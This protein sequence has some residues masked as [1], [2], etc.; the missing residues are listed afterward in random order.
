MKIVWSQIL[1]E[2]A[3]PSID[4]MVLHPFLD[5]EAEQVITQELERTAFQRTMPDLHLALSN[6]TGTFNTRLAG[7][8]AGDLYEVCVYDDLLRCRFWGYIDNESIRLKR[9]S[10]W[11]E[12]DAY[13]AL[14]RFWDKAKNSR[15]PTAHGWPETVTITYLVGI[16]DFICN[17]SDSGRNFRGL[18]FGTFAAESVRGG[19]TSTT[20]GNL[21]R[22]EDLAAETTVEDV[23]RA[24]AMWYNAEFYIDP[25][26]R[27]LKMV[28]RSTILNDRKV[29]L[30]ERLLEDEEITVAALDSETIDYVYAYAYA[31][32]PPAIDS[33]YR[34]TGVV[35]G[36]K[37]LFNGL[38]SWIVTYV[39]DG[40]EMFRSRQFDYTLTDAMGG[41]PYG[42]RL[43]IAPGPS[44]TASRYLYRRDA[45]DKTG[46]YRLCFGVAGNA[47]VTVSDEAGIGLIFYNAALPNLDMTVYGW[48]R[49]DEETDS[50]AA[51][52]IDMPVGQY[53]PRG[54]ILDINPQLRFF[55]YGTKD[56]LRD[57]SPREVF[58][59]F[60]SNFDIN[61]DE[62]RDRWR[63]VFRTRRLVTCNV[64]GIDWEVGDSVICSKWDIIP[65]DL[66]I[67]KRLVVRRSAINLNSETSV[68]DL[69]TV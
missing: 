69:R 4:D 31:G 66:T 52:I 15:F 58:A 7:I 50:W 41:P 45:N 20:Y 9:V 11:M 65:Q 18:N 57:Y 59:F 25:D 16:L 48:Y 62:T 38:H 17:L 49:Y 36:V 23:L 35:G 21:G 60:L 53:P 13:S 67:D 64:S 14:S 54:K 5:D 43:R 55:E 61:A 26:S 34:T 19:Y 27:Q 63:D 24:I 47:L 56:Q 6:L 3:Y 68:L 44:V 28:A 10:E 22:A 32:T 30:A 40:K 29:D 42:V 2:P 46:T 39:I 33:T 51:P 12:F 1:P 8:R 37:G